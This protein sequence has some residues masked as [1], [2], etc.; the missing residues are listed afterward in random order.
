MLRCT[1]ARQLYRMMAYKDE[2]EVARLHNSARFRE[3]LETGFAPGFRTA[4]HLVVPFITRARDGRG[5]P[6]KTETRRMRQLFP[7]L[8]RLKRLRGTAFDPFAWQHERRVERSLID[9]YLG[10]MTQYDSANDVDSWRGILGAASE[11]RGFGPVKMAA[12]ETV[13]ASVATQLADRLKERQA[14]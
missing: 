1:V 11:I 5:R 8:A 2:Y 10:L 9:W 12:I 6:K 3:K 4:N 7:M 14:G 13:K